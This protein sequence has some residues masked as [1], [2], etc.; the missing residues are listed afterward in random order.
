MPLYCLSVAKGYKDV[1]MWILFID[2]VKNVNLLLQ[3]RVQQTN[4][5]WKLY[6]V[7]PK[8]ITHLLLPLQWWREG[9]EKHLFFSSLHPCGGER[10]ILHDHKS[11]GKG[12]PRLVIQKTSTLSPSQKSCPCSAEGVVPSKAFLSAAVRFL[13][14]FKPLYKSTKMSSSTVWLHKLIQEGINLTRFYTAPE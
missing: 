10:R 5:S 9:K 6:F 11:G 14:T 4:T 13:V 3:N 7:F 1:V 12:N 8:T 2:A